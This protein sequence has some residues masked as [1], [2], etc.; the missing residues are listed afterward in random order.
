[1]RRAVT[2]AAAGALLLLALAP[3]DIAV[4]HAQAK[5]SVR[6]VVNTEG[7]PASITREDLARIFLGKKT[8]WDSDNRIVPCMLEESTPTGEAFLDEVLHK[9]VSQYRAYWKR[10][11][12]SGGGAPHISNPRDSWAARVSQTLTVPSRLAVAR[13]APSGLKATA[14][15]PP[16]WPRRVNRK[17]RS[18]TAS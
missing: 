15:T 1:M 14:S 5:L 4:L 9:N 12:F 10:L 8:L 2:G 16:V 11:L 6:I 13:R 7:T 17:P 3:R 18:R